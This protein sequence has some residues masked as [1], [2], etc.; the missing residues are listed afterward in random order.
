MEYLGIEE[1]AIRIVKDFEVFCKYIDNNRI[2]LTKQR[3]EIGRNDAFEINKNLYF[4]ED[5]TKPNYP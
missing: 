2:K 3:K 4:K 1:N 5:I